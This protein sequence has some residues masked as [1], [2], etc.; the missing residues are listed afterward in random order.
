M[1]IVIDVSY[2]GGG[3]NTKDRNSEKNWTKYSK[4]HQMSKQMLYLDLEPILMVERQWLQHAL[5]SAE[6]EFKCQLAGTAL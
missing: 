5:L 4:S 1:K 6:E 2:P 3:T